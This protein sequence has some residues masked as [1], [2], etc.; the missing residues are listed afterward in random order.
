M[1]PVVKNLLYITLKHGMRKGYQ[2]SC[3]L[4]TVTPQH[5][6]V[7]SRRESNNGIHARWLGEVEWREKYICVHVVAVFQIVHE[8]WVVGYESFTCFTHLCFY[9]FTPI[10]SNSLQEDTQFL[11][12][13]KY[14]ICIYNTVQYN[15]L[16]IWNTATGCLYLSWNKSKGKFFSHKR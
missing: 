14:N 13:F 3:I 10:T 8:L 5:S 1:L 7:R 12:R 15:I 2:R 9:V 6:R 11:L 4:L 16:T